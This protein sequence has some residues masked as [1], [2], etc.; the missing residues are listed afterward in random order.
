MARLVA[1]DSGALILLFNPRHTDPR[2]LY[3]RRFVRQLQDEKARLV[4][5][6]AALT[7]YL[8]DAPAERHKDYLDRLGKSVLIAPLNTKASSIAA[9]LWHRSNNGKLF[10]GDGKEKASL[11][12]DYLVVASAA[13]FGVAELVSYD[14]DIV[15]I[16]ALYAGHQ[17]RVYPFPQVAEQ[18]ALPYDMVGS[19]A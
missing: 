8:R 12:A 19:G 10:H 9:D 15:N 11:K 2:T 7:E 1:L 17:I 3:G 16:G 14:R 5:P 13:A 4:I 18:A 6:S